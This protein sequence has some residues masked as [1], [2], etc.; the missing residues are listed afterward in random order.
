M[1]VKEYITNDYKALPIQVLVADAKIFFNS[2]PFAHFPLIDNDS[3]VGLLSKQDIDK[4]T[5]DHK[6]LQE[7]LHIIPTIK[8]DSN[9]TSIDILTLSAFHKID[10]IPVTDLS[11]NYLGYYEFDDVLRMFF[12]TPFMAQNAT[13]LIVEKNSIDCSMSE[14]AQIVEANH[15]ELIGMYIADENDTMKQ[16]TLRIEAEF[17]NEVIQSLRRYGYNVLT[18]VKDD[19]F[20]EQMKE[21]SL[22]VE[23][24][25]S[26]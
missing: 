5:D 15:V 18:E 24:F 22:Y 10:I 4:L 11:G 9:A 6:T 23:K 12:K 7:V 20:M 16:V 8:V 3:Y 13:T 1:K 19:L 21:R 14:L 2:L 25:F 26:I 17:I